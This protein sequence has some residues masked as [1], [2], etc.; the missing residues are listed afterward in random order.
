MKLYWHP[1]SVMPWRVLIAL[2]EKN[3]PYQSVKIDV[4][5]SEQRKPDFLKINPF[6]QIPVLEDQGLTI[7][8]SMAIL[9]YLEE[10]YPVPALMPTAAEARAKARQLMCWGTDYWLPAWKK[11]IAPQ[12]SAEGWSDESVLEGRKELAA[13][14]DVLESYLDKNEWLAGSYSLAD[15]CYAPLVMFLGRVGLEDEISTRPGVRDWVMR[16]G[17]RPA[18]QEAMRA[19]I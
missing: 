16:L 11:W 7:A 19:E 3:L 1:F 17:E 9:E 8:E 15:I 12:L 4:L 6:G 10:R 18:V 5:T 2:H 13:H 14:L